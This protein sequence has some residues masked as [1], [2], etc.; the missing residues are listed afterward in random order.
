M[1][2]KTFWRN[3]DE[4]LSPVSMVKDL[5][6]Q[7]N[8]PGGIWINISTYST[9]FYNKNAN[10][11]KS[12]VFVV[13]EGK[14]KDKTRL[15]KRFQMGVPITPG[16]VPSQG[17]DRILT[18]F[19]GKTLYEFWQFRF[20]NGRYECSWGGVIEDVLKSDGVMPTFGH[21]PWGAS[22]SSLP[23]IA[24]TITINDLKKEKI[25]HL[26][27]VTLPHPAPYFVTPAT[28]T[29]GYTGESTGKIPYGQIIQYRKDIS[30]KST[31]PPIVK[32]IVTAGRDYG[33]IL[34]D[35]SGA[36]CFNAEDP[37]PTG[38]DFAP[39]LGNKKIYEIVEKIPM[40]LE[41]FRTK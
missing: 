7:A 3:T 16:T 2:N 39:Y 13:Q 30:I 10:V 21:E 19:D 34:R 27:A 14:V 26:L 40:A 24:G 20:A 15:H 23:I 18:I 35:K 32:M 17:T 29:D 9:T 25:E 8:V 22:A 33:F 37:R 1:F 12:P 28:R 6:N 38:F 31:W 4:H 36:V 41:D 11:K 5:V